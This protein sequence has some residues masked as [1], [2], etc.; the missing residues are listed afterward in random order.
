MTQVFSVRHPL[1]N[2]LPR[3]ALVL[4]MSASLA[5][6]G[7]L[8]VES[9]YPEND[10]MATQESGSIFDFFNFG[11]EADEAPVSGASE[12]D[13]A[14]T[15]AAPAMPQGL[16][17]NA[18]L[19]RA[20]LETA[21]FLPLAAADPIGG[22]VITDWYND[23]GQNDERVKLNIVISGLDLRA[24][25]LRVSLFREKRLNG[26]WTSVA[27]SPRAARQLENII[28][29]KARDYHIARGNR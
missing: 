19:W 6:C 12:T 15:E 26:R 17:V 29:T 22:T 13:A 25:A 7:G 23:P 1:Q 8:R 5:A 14:T 27:A 18:D 10:N 3:L 9:D 24:D 16:A 11:G 21:S 2:K 20:A 4:L 28:L